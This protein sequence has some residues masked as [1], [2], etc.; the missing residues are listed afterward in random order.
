MAFTIQQVHWLANQ[1]KYVLAQT[2]VSH[3]H[4]HKHSH[5]YRTVS[6]KPSQ[7]SAALRIVVTH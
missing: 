1:R 5:T 2:P 3:M 4:T 7:L 6:N